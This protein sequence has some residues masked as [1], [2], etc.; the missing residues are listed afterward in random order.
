M[1]CHHQ[2]LRDDQKF[3]GISSNPT[4]TMFTKNLLAR[5]CLMAISRPM[6]A[7]AIV[8][9]FSYPA[10]VVVNM[11]SLSPTMEV[12]TI[13]KWLVKPGDEIS[14]GVALAEVETDKAS[15]TFEAQEDFFI[16]KLLVEA[17]S[18][19]KVGDPIFVS[20]EDAS[21][22][23]AFANFTLS[24]AP[25]A[26]APAAVAPPAAAP[27]PVPAAPVAAPAPVAPKAPAPTPAPAAAKPAATPAKAATPAPAAQSAN[28]YA[29]RWGTA[30]KKG[31]IAGKLAAQHANYLEKYGR[32]AQKPL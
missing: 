3:T 29:W 24:N 31:A 15:M 16:A 1:L 12:G 2:N 4:A 17:G 18:E 9:N 14:A 5:R 11:P 19:V 10:H 26:A 27:V 6:Q 13:G 8:R 20:V 25:A 23:S 32:S 30:V 7:S 21:T 28:V 22:V